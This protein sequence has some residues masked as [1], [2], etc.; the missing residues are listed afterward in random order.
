MQKRLLVLVLTF[1]AAS[2]SGCAMSLA[3]R[4]RDLGQPTVEDVGESPDSP[5]GAR[6]RSFL[7]E[8]AIDIARTTAFVA[9]AKALAGWAP[10]SLLELGAPAL[11]IGGAQA[12]ILNYQPRTAMPAPG[13]RQQ[14]VPSRAT[15][16]RPAIC[17]SQ[18]VPP[19]RQ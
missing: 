18:P 4:D 16:S 11:P 12:P 14:M 8:T 3:Q 7:R 1:A 17:H 13:L 10:G 15:R 5:A 9:V 6:L 2:A 19:Q